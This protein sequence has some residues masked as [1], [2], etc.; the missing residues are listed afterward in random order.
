MED[1]INFNA[2]EPKKSNR[3]IINVVGTDIPQHLFVG[4]KM[5]NEGKT[6]IVETEFYETVEWTFNPQEFFDI[7]D[8]LIQHVNAVGDVI[9]TLD[10]KVDKIYY[11]QSG[12][13]SDDEF[14]IN[15]LKFVTSNCDVIKTEQVTQN[16]E[17][18]NNE[19]KTKPNEVY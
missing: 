10:F 18:T 1:N 11:E 12:R 3:F 17:E 9:S 4:Y 16:S 8:L 19:N 15:K 14:L 7:E 6:I 13:Y 2:F 5:F